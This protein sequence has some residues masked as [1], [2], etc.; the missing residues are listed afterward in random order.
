MLKH[1]SQTF[2]KVW[3]SR[4]VRTCNV[5]LAMG[6]VG[7]WIPRRV[8]R[9][10]ASREGFVGAWIPR[11]VRSEVDGEI[12]MQKGSQKLQARSGLDFHTFPKVSE[13]CYLQAATGCHRLPQAATARHRLPQVAGHPSS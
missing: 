13:V 12:D 11:R 1:T 3:Y 7:A 9:S 5:F 2:E 10:L 8:R 4:P 6:F